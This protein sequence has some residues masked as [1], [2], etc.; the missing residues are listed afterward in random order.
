MS[1][2]GIIDYG[3][4]NLA[5]V[6]NSFHTIGVEG[7]L[8]RTPADLTDITHL[9]LPG[10]GAFGDCAAALRKQNL[11]E[12]ICQWISQ[13]KPFL[14]I[15][16]GYQILFESSD[17]TPGA[18]GLGVFK[19]HVRRFADNGLKIPHMGW[20]AVTPLRAEAPIWTDMGESPYFYY[21]HSYYPVPQDKGLI[22]ATSSYGDTFAAAVI[23]GRVIA[24]QF[25]PEKS[26]VQG[27][28][29]LKNFLTL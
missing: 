6:C 15:C 7:K 4:G 20:N 14:G 9:V 8:V 26:Q 18:Q 13:D 12:S 10:V 23:K 1:K 2:L 22:A 16:I 11:A 29:L 24:T 28:R 17:E 3:A 19:G 21:V 27:L 25:H 5:S